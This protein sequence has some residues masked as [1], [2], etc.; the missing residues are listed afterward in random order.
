VF[1]KPEAEYSRYGY[2]PDRLD[3]YILVVRFITTKNGFKIGKR[4]K[5][6]YSDLP[7][8][9]SKDKT[10][11]RRLI[12]F[13]IDRERVVSCMHVL[14]MQLLMFVCMF[15]PLMSGSVADHSGAWSQL[16]Q[17]L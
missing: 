10:L 17:A 4:S 8:S 16:R 1:S 6:F 7:S 14:F 3:E 2:H 11:E 5:T 12:E 15:S 13:T 9:R